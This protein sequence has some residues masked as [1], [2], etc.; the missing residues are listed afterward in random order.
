MPI[1]LT[2]LKLSGTQSKMVNRANDTKVD[3]DLVA[4]V[5]REDRGTSVIRLYYIHV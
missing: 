3:G 4:G 5:I 1:G 2:Q